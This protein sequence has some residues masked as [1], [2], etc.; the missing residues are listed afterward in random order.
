MGLATF[1]G[2]I[3]PYEGKELSEDRPIK[4]IEPEAG[5]EYVFPVAQ[6]G[7]APA[8]PLVKKG[9]RV[10]RGQIIAELGGFISA[11]VVCS[12]SGTVVNIEP[13]M[14]VMGTMSDSII[15]K[16]DGLDESVPGF[17]EERDLEKLTKEEV[18][19]IV[20][21]AGIV[22]LG[23]A[24]FPTHVKMAPKNPDA[25]EYILVNA[26]ECEPYLT[27]DYRVMMER[28][29]ELI[30][31]V[32]VFLHLF[33]KAKGIIGIE[34]NK[35]Q[36]IAK[37]TEMVKDE[38]NIEVKPLLTKYPQGGERTLIYACTGREIN[39]TMLP[40]DAGCIV[41]NVNTV[42][43]IYRAVVKSVPLISRVVTITGDAIAEP[44][45]VEARIGT[46][47]DVLIA[48]CGGFKKEPQKL[49]SGG[50]MMGMAQF[51]TSYPLAKNT[52]ALTTFTV[53]QIKECAPTPCIR[54]GKCAEVCPEHLVPVLMMKAAE[55]MDIDKYKE[56]GGMECVE[57]GSC[58]YTCPAHRPLTQAFKLMRR[59]GRKRK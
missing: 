36:A 16:N 10:L 42:A 28:P 34:N 44:Q 8:K 27:H 11:N 30:G 22:G 52:S 20:K 26:A 25:I 58:A 14:T 54:C 35:P 46:S 48:A 49:I 37:L 40:A 4:V 12:V 19:Q 59:E 18:I 21:D 51:S 53:D 24:G 33:P 29:E 15:V 41:D 38:P 23:G 3:H 56:L 13:R 9:D 31:G 39:S 7:G 43:A 47:Y 32:K 17:G 1:I 50:P 5:M 45:N 55:R 2:G 57:C 6:A